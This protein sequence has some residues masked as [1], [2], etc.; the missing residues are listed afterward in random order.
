MA[1]ILY[2][3]LMLVF[4]ALSLGFLMDKA[5]YATVVTDEEG[6]EVRY[7]IYRTVLEYTIIIYVPYTILGVLW[8]WR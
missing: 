2:G 5:G 3:S 8:C 7:S 1:A 4:S 6:N